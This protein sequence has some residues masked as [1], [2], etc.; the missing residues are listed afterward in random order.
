MLS[1]IFCVNAL[2]FQCLLGYSKNISNGDRVEYKGNNYVEWLS[3]NL[4]T[5]SLGAVWVP[6]YNNQNINYCNYILNDCE[7][8]ILISDNVSTE[9]DSNT[10]II[11]GNKMTRKKA[12]II[13][14]LPKTNKVASCA[15]KNV[16]IESK[17]I[18]LELN[19]SE[20]YGVGI[21]IQQDQSIFFWDSD[22]YF[23]RDLDTKFL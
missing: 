7:P 15:E 9:Y 19:N 12:P 10:E 13:L 14:V 23:E 20:I 17:N 4:A 6:M 8:K 1:Q 11:N 21:R 18:L 22:P 16:I 2:I 3:W 5:N